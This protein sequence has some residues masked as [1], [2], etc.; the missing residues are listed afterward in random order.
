M[1]KDKRASISKNNKIKTMITTNYKECLRKFLKY[2]ILPSDD[3]NI[4]PDEADN[5]FEFDEWN[6]L[7]IIPS[8][9]VIIND[10]RSIPVKR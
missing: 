1:I 3:Y 2:S 7:D 10:P 4:Q 9:M 5:M 6:Y 8:L